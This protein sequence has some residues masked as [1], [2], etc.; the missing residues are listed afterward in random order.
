MRG[1]KYKTLRKTLMGSVMGIVLLWPLP[2]QAN[3][4]RILID[5]YHYGNWPVEDHASDLVNALRAEGFQ[6][7]YQHG[8]ITAS[9]L[10]ECDIF[11]EFFPVNSVPLTLSEASVLRQWVEVR[12]N[13]LWLG[14][15][16]NNALGSADELNKISQ[17]WGV[18]FNSNS[19]TGQVTNIVPHNVTNGVD[20]VSIRGSCSVAGGV[21]LIRTSGGA[22]IV[23][24]A[25]PGLGRVAFF[26][27]SLS[28]GILHTGTIHEA[29]NMTLAL[30]TAHWLVPEPT[31]VG[32]LGLG[33]LGLLR[34]RRK[35]S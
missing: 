11:V 33:S 14:G 23:S 2:G 35:Q 21:P 17:A 32:L 16:A 7:G 30:N 18:V 26:G 5:A 8:S 27:D 6:V 22:T 3:Q 13:G 9:V 15:A 10:N 24:I 25:E 4:A 31:T 1:E 12:G 20:T 29:D 34:S 19:Y 28:D